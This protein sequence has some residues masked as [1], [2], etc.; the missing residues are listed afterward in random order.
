MVHMHR[1]NPR[2]LRQRNQQIQQYHR[3][4]TTRQPD[5]HILSKKDMA[6]QTAGNSAGQIS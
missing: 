5:N 4:T 2:R 3:I 6:F 1:G